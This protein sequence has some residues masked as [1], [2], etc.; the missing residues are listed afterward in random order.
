MDDRSFL[1][2]RHLVLDAGPSD[3]TAASGTQND[4]QVNAIDDYI[5][6]PTRFDR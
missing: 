5:H 6:P 1:R 3:F 4:K 2:P